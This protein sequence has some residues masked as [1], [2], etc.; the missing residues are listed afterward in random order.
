LEDA[1]CSGPFG[2]PTEVQKK[3]FGS[4]YAA[5]EHLDSALNEAGVADADRDVGL[6][7]WLTLFYFDELCPKD[8]AGHRFLRE[9]PAYI[10]EPQNFQRYYRHL[11]LG[12]Y[13]IFRAHSDNPKRAMALLCQPLHIIDD[14][15][16]QLAAYQEIISNKTIIEMATHLY[17]DTESGERKKGAGGK[18]PGSPRRLAAVLDQF[19]V[20]WDLYAMSLK[21]FWAVLPNE[22]E[23]FR[24]ATP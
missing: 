9:R 22:F 14:I 10:P 5:A 15:I 16:A 3:T 2:T 19:D 13:L 8:K 21:E 12:P 17:L 7:A 24:P 1:V 6:W 11:L 4:R 18:G 20:T 23:K